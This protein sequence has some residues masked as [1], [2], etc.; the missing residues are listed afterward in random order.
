M[1]KHLSEYGHYVNFDNPTMRNVSDK[2]NYHASTDNWYVCSLV[3][4]VKPNKLAGVKAALNALP[5]TEIYAEKPEEGKLVVV[6]AADYQPILVER[7]EQM[8][9]IDGVIV[10]SLIYSQ[11]HEPS[12][13]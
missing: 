8:K 12:E 1:F 3:V 5:N 10:V 11:Q 6:L 13:Y 4:Q 9:D 7:M 2:L